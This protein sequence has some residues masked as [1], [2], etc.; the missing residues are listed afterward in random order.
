MHVQ[1]PVTIV[2]PRSGDHLKR[3]AHI[4]VQDGPNSAPKSARDAIQR[5]VFECGERLG[6]SR[7]ADQY[8]ET[9]KK[10]HGLGAFPYNEDVSIVMFAEELYAD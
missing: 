3:H 5:T 8:E 10:A 7:T 1:P 2:A 9:L 4:F 6:T